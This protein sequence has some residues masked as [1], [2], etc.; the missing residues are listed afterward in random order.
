M[1][2]LF[3]TGAAAGALIFGLSAAQACPGNAAVT[4]DAATLSAAIRST[5]LS[6]AKKPKKK[7]KASGKG[8]T[9]TSKAGTGGGQGGEG[10]AGS[11]AEKQTQTPRGKPSTPTR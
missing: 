2:R 5:D 10:G 4:A 7:K 8:A 11:A 1:K 6:A 3:L 9:A